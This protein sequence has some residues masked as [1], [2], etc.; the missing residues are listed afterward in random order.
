MPIFSAT[1]DAAILGP[2]IALALTAGNVVPADPATPPGVVDLVGMAMGCAP[3]EDRVFLRRG[4]G[5]AR[6]D[7]RAP[8]HDGDHGGHGHGQPQPPSRSHEQLGCLRQEAHVTHDGKAKSQVRRSVCGLSLKF[9]VICVIVKGARAELPHQVLELEAYG[10]TSLE[11]I[12]CVPDK[13]VT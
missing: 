10:G 13:R 8:D 3:V 1:I 12:L 6:R 5:L 2:A 4:L 7:H 9:H 11:R